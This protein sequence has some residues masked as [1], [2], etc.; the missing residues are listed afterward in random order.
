MTMETG[1]VGSPVA[2]ERLATK[3][4]TDEATVPGTSITLDERLDGQLRMVRELQNRC[5][6]IL[7]RPHPADEP[8]FEGA[9][10]VAAALG[11]ELQ[12][13]GQQISDI[14]ELV[15]KL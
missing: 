7:N 8:A 14:H 6:V 5:D 1:N 15:G 9:I 13:L 10:G 3:I 2:Q 11:D 4:L 12:R